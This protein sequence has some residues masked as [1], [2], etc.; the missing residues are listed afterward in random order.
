MEKK[1]YSPPTLT[2]HGSVID[3]TKGVIGFCYEVHGLQD[4]GEIGPPPPPTPPKN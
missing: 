3:L 4:D 1:P 2:D